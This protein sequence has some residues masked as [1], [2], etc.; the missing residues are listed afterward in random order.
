MA[1]APTELSAELWEREHALLT[2]SDALAGERGRMVLV[3]GEAGIGKTAVVR[4]FCD[5]APAQVRVLFGACDPLFTPRALGPFED[6]AALSAPALADALRG[7][8]RPGDVFAALRTEFAAA[9]TMLVLEDIHWADEATLDVMQLLGRRIESL[10]ALVIATFRDDELRSGH[11]LQAVLG[12]LATARGIEHV[13]LAAL[14]PEAVAAMAD[15][16]DVAA[17]ELYEKTGGNPFLV[18]QM[19]AADGD[20]LPVSLRAAVESRCARLSP[21]AQLVVKAVSVAPSRVDPWLLNRLGI[22]VGAPLHEA[23]AA[24]VLR[25]SERAVA[26]PHELGRMAV[27]SSLTPAEAADLHSRMLAALESDGAPRPDL[28]RL[29]HH[30]HAAGDRDAVARHAPRA[31]ERAASLGAHR[32]AAAHYAAAL[33]VA[34]DLPL[35]RQAELLERHSFECFLTDQSDG[36]IDSLLRVIELYRT[37]G[38]R[39]REGAALCAL[40]RRYGCAG[41]LAD[42][43]AAGTEAIAILEELP[44]TR[45]LGFAYGLEAARHMGE[46]D[47]AA[48][49]AWGSRG[50]EVAERF[51]DAETVA[52]C[53]NTVGTARLLACDAGGLDQLVESLELAEAH[54]NEDHVGR[55]H[56]HIAWALTRSR[57]DP[58]GFLER[59]FTYCGDHGLDL[60]SLYLSAYKARADLDHGRWDDAADAVSTVLERPR[61]APLLSTLALVVL[62]LLR[63]RRGDPGVWE[64]L[65]EAHELAQATG[66]LHALFEVATARAEAAWLE[67]RPEAIAGETESALERA[68]AVQAPWILGSLAT[69]RRCAGLAEDAP[70]A[71]PPYAAQLAGDW[72]R[73]AQLWDELGC[74]YEAALAR[75]EAEDEAAALDAHAELLRLGA[76]P[77]AAIVARRLRERGIRTLPRGPRSETRARP[78]GL[79][80]REE[81]ILALLAEGLSNREMAAALFLSTRTVEHHVSAI[82]RKLDVPSRA[83]A[84]VEAARLG[85]SP[86]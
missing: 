81:E 41:R 59:G 83:R 3:A 12:E 26:F 29:A 15:G 19:L 80:A 75:A 6:V 55:A 5:A 24:G 20:E 27:E 42:S 48:A 54:A 69:W 61:S 38:D 8:S 57:E 11:P 16:H 82:L 70:G 22:D 53:L 40:S 43:D 21:E 25:A 64:A 51:D 73:A 47:L 84:G 56:L 50:I 71:A 79:T 68:T 52:Y 74:P 85:I 23:I 72:T 9:P 46:E 7:D 86:R 45:E 14:S 10:G 30:A 76:R 66:E 63:A 35:E 18:T 33:D 67:G 77:A 60:W 36:A 2:L 1:V 62:G 49:I 58:Q 78:A 65:D 34:H 39:R 32:E 28:A 17:D 13:S 37:L 4:A 44:P 31:A